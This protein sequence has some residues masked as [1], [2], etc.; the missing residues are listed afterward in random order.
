MKLTDLQPTLILCQQVLHFP[1]P[2]HLQPN[3]PPL[4]AKIPSSFRNPSPTT[5][6]APNSAKPPANGSTTTHRSTTNG[7]LLL[8]PLRNVP[9]HHQPPIPHPSSRHQTT[10]RNRLRPPHEKRP[11]AAESTI[12][13]N[14]PMCV[15]NPFHWTRKRAS[16]WICR[17]D[18]QE[19]V[20]YVVPNGFSLH[21]NGRRQQELVRKSRENQSVTIYCIPKGI[22]PLSPSPYSSR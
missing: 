4:E 18:L 2:Q 16:V 11:R 3:N 19:C 5:L 9:P 15:L 21:T 10:S 8:L 1:R 17:T 6:P 12:S 7:N 13:Q 20:V 22:S 14:L